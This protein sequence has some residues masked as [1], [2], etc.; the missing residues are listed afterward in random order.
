MNDRYLN[1]GG[2]NGQNQV[3]PIHAHGEETAPVRQV[4]NDTDEHLDVER[5]GESKFTLVH[6]RQVRNATVDVTRSL[7]D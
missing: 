7:Q 1:D 5:N 2:N 4:G 6:D 3:Q